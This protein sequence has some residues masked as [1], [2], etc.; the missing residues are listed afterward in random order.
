VETCRKMS[1]FLSQHMKSLLLGIFI[2]LS[3]LL[4]HAGKN[5]D[6]LMSLSPVP[7]NKSILK[8]NILKPGI[9]VSRIELRNLIGR[10]LQNKKI[11]VGDKSIEF[12]EME[13]YPNGMY[14]II[15]KDERGKII[16]TS[17]FLINR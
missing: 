13:S 8:V 6:P 12:T 16:E 15:A 3:S 1:I 4:V 5:E 2:T 10:E 14:V 9:I 11:P 17:K 7:L